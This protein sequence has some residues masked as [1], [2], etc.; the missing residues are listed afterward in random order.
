MALT[1]QKVRKLTKS[2]SEPDIKRALF[3]TAIQI[4]KKQIHRNRVYLDSLTQKINI[5]SD[6]NF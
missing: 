4:I 6:D 5:F 2:T 1:V 3:L